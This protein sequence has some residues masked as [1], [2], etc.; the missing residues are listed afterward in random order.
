MHCSSEFIDVGPVEGDRSTRHQRVWVLTSHARLF[1][2]KV[3]ARFSSSPNAHLVFILSQIS[4]KF[5]LPT[6]S[7]KSLSHCSKGW[8]YPGRVQGDQ[9]L[10]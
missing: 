10:E 7:S 1:G 6:T 2:S 3:D 4:Q 5:R 9:A 8:V